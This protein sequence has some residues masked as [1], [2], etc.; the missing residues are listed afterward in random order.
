MFI[1]TVSIWLPMIFCLP[2]LC[3]HCATEIEELPGKVMEMTLPE[4]IS[5]ALR[6]NRSIQSAYMNRAIQRFDLRVAEDEFIP[7]LD[8][9][10][11]ASI[12]RNEAKIFFDDK[13][14]RSEEETINGDLSVILRERIPTGAD[15]SFTWSGGYNKLDGTSSSER[16]LDNSWTF[17]AVQPLLK[18]GGIG[19][20]MTNLR[21]ARLTEQSNIWSLKS[22]VIAIVTQVIGAYRS[23]LQAE[24]QLEISQASLE[25]AKS[26][27]EV[28][29]ML[30]QS[31][32]MAAVEIVQTEADV[33]NRE[34]S[35]QSSLNSL[36][37]TRLTLLN[38]L[39]LDTD[40]QVK[41]VETIEI[42]PI[43]PEP[44]ECIALAL[45]SQPQYLIEKLALRAS[46][47]GLVVAR[48]NLLPDLSVFFNFVRQDFFNKSSADSRT[49]N[50]AAGLSLSVP[51]YGDLTREQGYLSSK[52][53]VQ[54]QKLQ[55][56]QTEANIKTD[57]QGKV[58]D[59]KTAL[60]Q[61]QLSEQARKLAE[62]KLRIEQDKLAL[63]RSTNFQIVSFQNDLVSAQLNEL[64]SKIAYLNALTALDAVLGTTLDTWKIRFRSEDPELE[65]RL[66]D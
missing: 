19:V 33:A 39:A 23:F 56:E 24:K 5:L 31:G 64:N 22:Q 26:L 43:E 29:K 53:S 6:F 61:V 12:S 30:I 44:R 7:N 54:R 15:F 42:E 50:W 32:R 13:T 1:R 59:I 47:L 4:A 38:L 55:V 25:R 17:N 62:R 20:N 40:L 65:R 34:F 49:N 41:P 2:P 28:N 3:A 45:D 66:R 10:G 46:E 51:L 14:S 11:E 36:N 27:L 21:I 18:G 63:G 37:N 57:V 58:R 60:M 9:T 35:Y 16:A 48:N 8:L 52:T